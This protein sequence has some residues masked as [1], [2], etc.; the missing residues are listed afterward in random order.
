MDNVGHN[1]WLRDIDWCHSLNDYDIILPGLGDGSI[2]IW[3]I[4]NLGDIKQAVE[5]NEMTDNFQEPV[6][7]V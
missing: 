1:G 5:A 3:K 6:W 2:F 4:Y 7:N